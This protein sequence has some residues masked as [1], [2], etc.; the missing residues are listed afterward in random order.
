MN[1]VAQ[2]FVLL[3]IGG[4]VLKITLDGT[5]L[6][7]VKPGLQPY[8]IVS[9]VALT[10]LALLTI[11]RDIRRGWATADSDHHPDRAQWLLL[12]P[13]TALLIVVPPALGAGSVQSGTAVQASVGT[14]AE[15][16][17]GKFAFPPLPVGDAPTIRMYELIDRASYDSSGA[18]DRRDITVLG[19]VVRTEN[20]GAPRT[21]GTRTGVDL[22]RLVITC[23]VADA[24]LLRVHLSGAFDPPPDDT[25]VSVRGRVEPNSART[26]TQM[27][28]TLQVTELHPIPTPARVYG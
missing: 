8:L 19:F 23:C 2:N 14:P 16:G 25:W 28:P 22:A 11:G 17:D 24:Q 6:R 10:L 5:Y 9:G 21:D 1:R 12:A 13:I 20:D 27:T 4:A 15:T 7:Y 18:L 3:L 26:E